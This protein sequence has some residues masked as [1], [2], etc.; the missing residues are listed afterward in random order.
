[1]FN[2]TKLVVANKQVTIYLLG[3]EYNDFF[4]AAGNL[5]PDVPKK[6]S[7]ACMTGWS[8]DNR[9]LGAGTDH[10]APAL[11]QHSAATQTPLTAEPEADHP[12]VPASARS[13]SVLQFP[14][15]ETA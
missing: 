8:A 12:H 4:D 5:R 15:K 9:G 1:M 6:D 14:K 10:S 13:A 3:K 11:S 7:M 2:E